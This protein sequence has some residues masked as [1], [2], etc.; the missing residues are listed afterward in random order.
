V[1]WLGRRGPD[2][3]LQALDF[4]AIDLETTGLD[5]RRDVPVA[6]AA[7]PF[8]G[9]EPRPEAGYAGL[10][11]PG[12][13]IPGAAQAIHGITDADV[14][15][16]PLVAAALPE[17]LGV[18]RNCVIVAHAA[19]FDLTIINRAARAARLPGLDNRTLDVGVLAHG[20]LPSWWDLSLDGLARLT[21]VEPVGRH[22]AEGD[23]VTAG[24]VFLRLIPL[25]EQH[26]VRTL[27]GALRVQRRAALLPAGP[28]ATGGGLSGP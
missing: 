10:V 21:E 22:S 9:G 23:A 1:L 15:E 5:T 25:L 28:G 14:R 4:V 20:L 7:I 16:A 26:G 12:R 17:F 19:H 6:L 24:Y 2:V 11:N 8:I 18:C 27:A 3:L 13:P